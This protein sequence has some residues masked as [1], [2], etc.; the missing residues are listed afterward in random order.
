MSVLALYID[1][2]VLC[3][4]DIFFMYRR[5]YLCLVTLLVVD[6]IKTIILIIVSVSQFN[7]LNC[8]LPYVASQ[9]WPYIIDQFISLEE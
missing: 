9:T 3:N 7:S 1:E 6:F 4:F 2:G 5:T 8:Y